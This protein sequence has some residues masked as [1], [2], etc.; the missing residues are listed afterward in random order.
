LSD[1]EDRPGQFDVLSITT[2]D[3]GESFESLR[4]G[5]LCSE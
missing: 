4:S 1:W 3:E 5:N 2:E